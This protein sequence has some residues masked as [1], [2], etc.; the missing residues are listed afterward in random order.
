MYTGEVV[1]AMAAPNEDA[2]ALLHSVLDLAGQML[3]EYGEFYPYGGAMRPD[4]EIVSVAAE[5]GDDRPP[6]QELIDLLKAGLR[7][8]AQKGDFKATAIV[9]DVLVTPPGADSKSD[10]IAVAIDHRDDYSVVIVLPYT[11]DQ[12]ELVLG[13]TFVQTGADDIFGR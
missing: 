1:V 12:G 10:A 7:E 13:E 2:E 6:S 8:G 4:G 3:S 5:T 9:F 11:L